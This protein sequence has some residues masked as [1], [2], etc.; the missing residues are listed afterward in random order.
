MRKKVKE[1]LPIGTVL[2]IKDFNESLII[3]QNRIYHEGKKEKYD[4]VGIAYP[5][6]SRIVKNFKQEEIEEIISL[7]KIETI[8]DK[9]KQKKEVK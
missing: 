6:D 7:G 4:Y 1:L 2:T 9:T 8:K 3:I 5:S